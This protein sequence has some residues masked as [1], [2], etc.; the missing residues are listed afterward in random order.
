MSIGSFWQ[1]VDKKQC[2]PA[3]ALEYW[4]EEHDKERAE[5][6]EKEE[7]QKDPMDDKAAMSEKRL[8][9][10]ARAEAAKKRKE[11]FEAHYERFRYKPGKEEKKDDEKK[12]PDSEVEKKPE[13]KKMPRKSEVKESSPRESAPS[14]PTAGPSIP[15][16]SP[17]TT[18]ADPAPSEPVGA[19]ASSA[20]AKRPGGEQEERSKKRLEMSPTKGQKRPVESGGE[21]SKAKDSRAAS[22][23]ASKGTKR[24]PENERP[25]DIDA[26]LMN[27]IMG[28]RDKYLQSIEGEQEPV[29]EETIPLPPELEDDAVNWYYYDDISGKILD[30][31]GVEKARKDEVEIIESFPVWEKIPRHKMPKGAWGAS[32]TPHDLRGETAWSLASRCRPEAFRHLRSLLPR[33]EP[34]AGA[35]LLFDGLLVLPV[36]RANRTLLAGASLELSNPT[37]LTVEKWKEAGYTLFQ[38]ETFYQQHEDT[39]FEVDMFHDTITQHDLRN[40]LPLDLHR[41]Q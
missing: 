10:I 13:V 23:Q 4:K 16:Q 15:M 27:L 3:G 5:K 30:S 21:T 35:P 25:D 9:T 38:R 24:P 37:V 6:A 2:Y 14:L 22:A 11:Y 19:S 31:K 1:H 40:I 36:E 17:A 39:N 26:C 28:D 20:S 12:A 41:N 34:A 18:Q 32:T 8:Q 33:E 29:C 7:S